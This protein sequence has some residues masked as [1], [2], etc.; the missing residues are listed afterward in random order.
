MGII[1]RPKLLSGGSPG[2]ARAGSLDDETYHFGSE[3]LACP[4]KSAE[5]GVMNLQYAPDWPVRCVFKF[6][7]VPFFKE[8]EYEANTPPL[9][10]K[11]QHPV[12]VNLQMVVHPW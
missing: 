3:S 6:I 12:S 1:T 2:Q 10:M 11:M 7:E 8:A 4:V 5:A 9:A